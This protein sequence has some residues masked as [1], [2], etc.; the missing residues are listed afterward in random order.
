MDRVVPLGRGLDLA[1]KA[2]DVFT[3]SWALY[4]VAITIIE[5]G[6]PELGIRIAGAADAARERSGG[7]LPPP[8]IPIAGPLERAQA[9]LGDAASDHLEAGRELA[10]LPAMALARNAAG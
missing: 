10:L 9:L 7:R 1:E 6:D 5:L 2:G 8:F 3:M 4:R